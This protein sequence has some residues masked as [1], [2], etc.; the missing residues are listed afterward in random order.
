MYYIG[1]DIGSTA[2]KTTVFKGNEIIENFVVPT[3]WSSVETSQLI[4]K[5]LN[6][7][8]IYKENSK[9]VATGYG[10]VSVPYADKTVTEITCH[11]KG[12]A[13][14]SGESCTVID[15]GGQDTKVITVEDGIIVDFIMN[16]KCSAGTGRF[17]EIMANTLGVDI[18]SLCN[19]ASEGGGITIS[20]MCTVFAESEV[21]GLI[22][23]G[24]KKEDIAY[25]IVDSVIS[26]VKSLCIKHNEGYNYFLTGGL[27]G[28]KYIVDS[29]SKKL[30]K[31]V[32]TH[33]LAKYAGS[34]GAALIPQG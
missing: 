14:L 30:N 33:S 26:K 15:I 3:G 7:M 23:R 34:I 29:L 32:R 22:G 8:G 4:M 21:I 24:E 1:I 17:L 25:A 2:A 6:D 31:P 18:D 5:R 27:S 12:A 28:N 19:L 11:G 20:S 16:D 10:R 9:I 13:Y